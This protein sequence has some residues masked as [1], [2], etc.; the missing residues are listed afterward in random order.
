MVLFMIFLSILFIFLRSQRSA[1][2]TS[3]CGLCFICFALFI[4]DPGLHQKMDVLLNK[5]DKLE[6]GMSK[7]TSMQLRLEQHETRLVRLEKQMSRVA[8]QAEYAE[9]QDKRNNLIFNGIPESADRR[10]N[11]DETQQIIRD[12][13]KDKMKINVNLFIQR[14]HRMQSRNN[15]PCPIVVKFGDWSHREVILKNRRNLSGTN[16]FVSE[17]Y[18][19]RIQYIRSRLS[20]EFGGALDENGRRARLYYDKIWFSNCQYTWDENN[21]L[22]MLRNLTSQASN[23]QS[24]EVSSHLV[25]S[26]P[27]S[28]PILSQPG[29]QSQPSTSQNYSSGNGLGMSQSSQHQS[30]LTSDSSSMS[31][32]QVMLP[33]QTSYQT[34]GKSFTF[35][36]RAPNTPPEPQPQAVQKPEGKK[37]RSSSRGRKKGT[38]SSRCQSLSGTR[39]NKNEEQ[40]VNEDQ[41]WITDSD[42]QASGLNNIVSNE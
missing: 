29:I 42:S 21:K 6:E 2:V 28:Q 35:K 5:I 13:V 30:I 7:L 39:N 34:R 37:V 41:D 27:R 26:Q 32:S 3:V 36:R 8:K 40:V 1:S 4:M 10:E 17:H 9:A 31:S 25:S 16:I 12:V 11:W 14:A 18:T 24:Q 38:S 19:G 15:G 23:F 20:R 22:I 33:I